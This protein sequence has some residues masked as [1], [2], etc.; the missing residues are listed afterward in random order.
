MLSLTYNDDNRYGHEDSIKLLVESGANMDARN[1]QNFTPFH[2]ALRQGCL[3]GV[4]QLLKCGQ[5]VNQRGGTC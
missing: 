5:D 2:I 1:D 4:V 3:E